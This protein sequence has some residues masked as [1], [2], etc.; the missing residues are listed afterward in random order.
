MASK[1]AGTKQA[2]AL[3]E[4]ILKSMSREELLECAV[5]KIKE[6]VTQTPSTQ[7]EPVTTEGKWIDQVGPF[8]YRGRQVAGEARSGNVSFSGP[9]RVSNVTW[10]LT[11]DGSEVAAIGEASPDDI[12]NEVIEWVKE[13][14]DR[15]LDARLEDA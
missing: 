4:N 6:P 11:I 1:R 2:E 12:T 5:Y 9:A 3:G 10:H 14:A 15:Y 8:P 7:R 13:A